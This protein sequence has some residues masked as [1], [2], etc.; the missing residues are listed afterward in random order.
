M[1]YKSLTPVGLAL[2][3]FLLSPE[4]YN[5]LPDKW[6]HG[7]AALAV[8]LG[9]LFPQLLHKKQNAEVEQEGPQA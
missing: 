5:V 1:N 4:F 7:I 9:L 2:A 3:G 6:A 8:L